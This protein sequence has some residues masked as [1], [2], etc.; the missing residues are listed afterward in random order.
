VLWCQKLE[1]RLECKEDFVGRLEETTIENGLSY[2]MWLAAFV[3]TK[4]RVNEESLTLR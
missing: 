2:S 3:N 4:A 1:L